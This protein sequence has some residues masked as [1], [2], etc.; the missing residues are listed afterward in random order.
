MEAINHITEAALTDDPEKAKESIAAAEER[1]QRMREAI[2]E[3]QKDEA[4]RRST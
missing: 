4:A 3:A 1:L 2:E